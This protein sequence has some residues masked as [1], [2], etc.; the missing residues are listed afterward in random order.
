MMRNSLPSYSNLGKQQTI[1]CESVNVSSGD[2]VS[3]NG[4]AIEKLC[5]ET[6]NVLG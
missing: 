5:A 4:L 6:K 3:L 1:A 2:F